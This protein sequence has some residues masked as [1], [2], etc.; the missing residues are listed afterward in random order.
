[1]ERIARE[2]LSFARLFADKDESWHEKKGF[3]PDAYDLLLSRLIVAAQR[4]GFSVRSLGETE[5][6]PILLFSRWR[7]KTLGPNVLI[8]GAIHGEENAGPWGIL[9]FLETASDELN[10][11]N[12]SFIPVVNPTGFRKGK[13]ENTEGET[14]NGGYVNEHDPDVPSREDH[15]LL[16]NMGELKE[17]AK[18]A[19]LS[20]H[21]DD[22]TK[23]FYLYAIEG[24]D[25]DGTPS[26][27]A[28]KVLAAGASHFGV[29]EDQKMEFPGGGYCRDGIVLNHH[30]G[31]L[32]DR[33]NS[34]GCPHSFAT[35]TPE[36]APMKERIE[37]VA[38]VIRALL[39]AVAEEKS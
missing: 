33:M 12:L 22:E 4:L 37:A 5:H 1:M 34:D 30:D 27:M 16:D 19:F 15:I 7:E 8:V 23:G 31:T 24:K 6:F 38:D 35:E 36:N 10:L 11:V 25:E 29:I 32:E 17:L 14:S 28:K 26:E 9:R 3:Q 20:L 21:E 2:F 13:R 39:K 18:D